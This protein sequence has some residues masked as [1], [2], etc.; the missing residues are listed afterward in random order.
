MVASCSI[1]QLLTVPEKLNGSARAARHEG[2]GDGYV[3]L[4]GRDRWIHRGPLGPYVLHRFVRI[5]IWRTLD[6]P[7][8]PDTHELAAWAVRAKQA[9]V[10]AVENL[11]VL[12]PLALLALQLDAGPAQLANG[13]CATYFFA[14]LAHF[15]V[16]V[17]GAPVVRTLAFLAG[18][19]AQITL[20]IALFGVPR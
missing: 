7:Q 14:R 11:A 3:P 15:V 4:A 1:K 19:T 13:A 20:L 10:N 17:A 8:P 18:L 2:A 12:A 9:H 5:G 6:N 16:Y